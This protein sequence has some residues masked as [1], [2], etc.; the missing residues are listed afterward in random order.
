MTKSQIIFVGQRNR[1]QGILL[2][3]KVMPSSMNHSINL[4]AVRDRLCFSSL[5]QNKLSDYSIASC[6]Y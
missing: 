5:G 1:E 6:T 3:I 2:S 4:V